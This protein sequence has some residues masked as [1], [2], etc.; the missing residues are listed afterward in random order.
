MRLMAHMGTKK[1]AK[2]A[3]QYDHIKKVYITNIN[4]LAKKKKKSY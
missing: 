1:N 3:E 2:S 4:L